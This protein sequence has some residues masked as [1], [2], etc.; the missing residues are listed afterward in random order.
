MNK[1]KILSVLPFLLLS[2]CGNS[3]SSAMT[4]SHFKTDKNGKL[5]S[6]EWFTKEN[7]FAM[8]RNEPEEHHEL[9]L[10]PLHEIG[11]TIWKT[12]SRKANPS[13]PIKL[14]YGVRINESLR[15]RETIRGITPSV[16]MVVSYL[17]N[18]GNKQRADNFPLQSNLPPYQANDYDIVYFYSSELDSYCA[19]YNAYD[20]FYFDFSQIYAKVGDGVDCRFYIQAYFPGAAEKNLISA[21]DEIFQTN[22]FSHGHFIFED[23]GTK[24]KFSRTWFIEDKSDYSQW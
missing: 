21:P 13:K 3:Q 10:E 4:D 7:F 16:R 19:L 9:P 24:M 15:T 5:Y 23:N 8:K 12:E 6:T 1:I 14:T 22:G 20:S 18:S 17:N 2:G 11:L